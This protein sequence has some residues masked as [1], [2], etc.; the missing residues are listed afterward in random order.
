[1]GVEQA[2]VEQ[3]KISPEQLEAATADRKS[4]TDRVDR[5]LVQ[6]GFEVEQ[7]PSFL[8]RWYMPFPFVLL[9]AVLATLIIVFKGPMQD[10]ALN[11]LIVLGTFYGIQGMVIMGH[12]FAKWSIPNM[13][14]ILMLMFFAL[15][16]PMTLL[17]TIALLGLFDIWI[18]F[19]RRF[20]IVIEED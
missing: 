17:L 10:V 1:M 19:R 20:P 15:A 6:K 2:L 5:I 4:P 9:F 8:A 11:G 13:F 18:D 14:R 12:L 3:G 7:D 16:Y